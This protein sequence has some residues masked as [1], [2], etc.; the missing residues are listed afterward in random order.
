MNTSHWIVIFILVLLLLLALNLIINY[1]SRKNQEK[2]PP[3]MVKIWL[4]PVLA[5]L[6]IIP[7]A[8][9]TMVYNLFFYSFGEI[10]NFLQFENFGDI[11]VFSILIITGFILF[12]TLVHPIIVA[13]LNYGLKKQVSIYTRNAITI[14]VDSFI[15]YIL[16]SSFDGIYIT[17]FWSA[18]SI[19]V[20][21][22]IIEWVFTL[23]YK[24]FKKKNKNNSNWM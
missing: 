19:S 18:L 11:T 6:I 8:V 13:L 24:S 16:A 17:D 15:I 12:E 20:F 9:F 14:L 2:S 21:Y 3:I 4:V 23:C 5:T 22:H 7:L 10:S 1:I